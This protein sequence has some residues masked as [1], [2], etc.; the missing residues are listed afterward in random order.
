MARVDEAAVTAEGYWFEQRDTG[1]RLDI[2]IARMAALLVPSLIE[3]LREFL[4]HRRVRCVC[5]VPIG[6]LGRLPLHALESASRG[7]G[8]CL[9]DEFDVVYAPSAQ[10][11]QVCRVR[12]SRGSEFRRL[13]AVGN[14][15]PSA[16][17]LMYA[18]EEALHVSELVRAEETTVLVGH[19]ATKDAVL[20]GLLRASHVHLA[21]H[22]RGT[23]DPWAFDSAFV[24][25]GDVQV[26][27]MEILSIDM[28]ETRLVTA[29]AC[30]TAVIPGYEAADEVLSIA[31]VLV[32]AGAAGAVASLWR[33]DDYATALMMTRF[34][35]EL[36]KMP[37][38]P[39]RALRLA[40]LWLRD[41]TSEEEERHCARHPTLAQMRGTV[42]GFRP[43]PYGAWRQYPSLWGGLRFLGSLDCGAATSCT[44]SAPAPAP[45][46]CQSDAG[47]SARTS[48]RWP[49]C[50]ASGT[51]TS[52]R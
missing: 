3:P 6:L 14:P 29:S 2:E 21:C 8:G 4:R 7:A 17:P 22:G 13:L 27:A 35:E 39:A 44:F 41:L 25:G 9:L 42:T 47:I 33:V 15:L 16:K 34:Y 10:A 38:A 24:L 32:G 18:E 45:G 40:S 51:C 19:D 23:G 48:P 43:V 46:A 36:V 30:E 52:E 49:S 37:A 5:L 50:G 26:S 12:A 1:P 31:T 11:R 28:S 20:G